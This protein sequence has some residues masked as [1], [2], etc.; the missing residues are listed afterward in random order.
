MISCTVPNIPDVAVDYPIKVSLNG[1]EYKTVTIDDVE[2]SLL[3]EVDINVI[4]IHPDLGFE[5]D[6]N[7]EITV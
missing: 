1:I 5:D 4:S 6:S 3:F 2:Q 7:I